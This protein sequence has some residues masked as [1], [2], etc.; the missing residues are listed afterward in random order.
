MDTAL[1]TLIVALDPAVQ[2]FAAEAIDR[3][4]LQPGARPPSAIAVL[5]DVRRKSAVFRLADA[6]PNGTAV[7]AK[8]CR[9]EGARVEHLVY[10]DILD[11]TSAS[12]PRLFGWS[13]E[14]DAHTWLF[15]EDVGDERWLSAQ[16]EH[17]RLAARWFGTVHRAAAAF[18]G[19]L[20]LP[21]RGAAYY[22][23]LLRDARGAME[24][25]LA[26][27]AL[28]ADAARVVRT[29]AESLDTLD[30]GW[31]T[32]EDVLATVPSTVTFPGFCEKNA[33]VRPGRLGLELLPYDFENTGWGPPVVE[34][35]QVD[36][37][38][39]VRSVGPPWDVSHADSMRLAALGGALGAV[40]SLPG[41]RPALTS[42]WPQRAIYKLPGYSSQVRLGI[43]A[44]QALRG[45]RRHE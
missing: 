14:S 12:H 24:A 22:R 43:D 37:A 45:E 5:K 10:T 36:M 32:V 26:N 35:Q 39:Y 9:A 17:R 16:R 4:S 23:A 31:P 19:S 33:R 27:A 3:W 8:R 38:Q 30:T 34:M 18:A 44:L 15:I 21:A 40:K 41:E 28:T 6:A 11:R 20:G 42:Q 2:P 29:L 7:V 25:A 13:A 1:G